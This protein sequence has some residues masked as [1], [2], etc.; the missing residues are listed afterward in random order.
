MKRARRHTYQ[1]LGNST[2]ETIRLAAEAVSLVALAE[3]Q[4]SETA[5]TCGSA[6]ELRR[7]RKFGGLVR[8]N[9]AALIFHA[10]RTRLGLARTERRV[11]VFS[12]SVSVLGINL[13]AGFRSLSSRTINVGTVIPAR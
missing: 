4:R 6:V 7:W 3:D 12:V 9:V 5:M 1:F 11:V 2:Q 8:A 10:D 13:S